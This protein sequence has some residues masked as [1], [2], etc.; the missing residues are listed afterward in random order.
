MTCRAKDTYYKFKGTST[1]A[2]S[3]LE[4]AGLFHER[5][6]NH[7]LVLKPVGAVTGTVAVSIRT[8]DSSEWETLQDDYGADVVVNLASPRTRIFSGFFT[9][10]K[11]T[12]TAVSGTYSYEVK[13]R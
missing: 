9:A 7:Q 5:A 8:S 3:P 13:G 11:F 2:A 6:Y 4:I 12:G 1:Q 10:I